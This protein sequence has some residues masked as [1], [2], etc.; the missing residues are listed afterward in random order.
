M[1]KGYIMKIQMHGR[2][3]D[4]VKCGLCEGRCPQ[5]LE[6]RKLLVDVRETLEA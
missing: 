3:L 1:L 6:I 5:H 4:C 2:P